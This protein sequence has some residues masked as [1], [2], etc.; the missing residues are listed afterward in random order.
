[1][2][3]AD[4]PAD[5]LSKHWAYQAIYPILKPI[6]FFSGNTAE[7][8]PEGRLNTSAPSLVI[9]YVIICFAFYI[10]LFKGLK[11]MGVTRLLMFCRLHITHPTATQQILLLSHMPTQGNYALVAGDI[12][13]GGQQCSQGHNPGLV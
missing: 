11:M 8:I 6:L 10:L 3:S 4:N 9:P 1:M 7:L 12:N 2:S 5:I 13:H